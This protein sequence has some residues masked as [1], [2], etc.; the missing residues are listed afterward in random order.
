VG[1]LTATDYVSALIERGCG[2]LC[3][4]DAG[5]RRRMSEW[6]LRFMD[7]MSRGPSPLITFRF[8]DP[9]PSVNRVY[10]VQRGRKILTTEAR[11][12]KNRFVTSR[13]GASVA[14]LM[15]L[16]L[17][18]HDQ[19]HLVIWI[20]LEEK[21]VINL[22]FGK[23]KRTK[24]PYAKVDTSN[25]FKLAEDAVTDLLGITCDRQNF[26]ISAHKRVAL[27]R[28][29]RIVIHLFPFETYEDPFDLPNR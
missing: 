9:P 22:G 11:K 3:M 28:G 15:K 18:A 16:D 12:W 1:R 4:D 19:F 25:F 24:Y 21:E 14:D 27:A 6:V 5:D 10:T 23:D 17:D 8:S 26:K 13:G 20:Y 2:S 29:K 7:D